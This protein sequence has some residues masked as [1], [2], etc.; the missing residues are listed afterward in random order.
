MRRIV[1]FVIC[2]LSSYMYSQLPLDLALPDDPFWNEDAQEANN[3]KNHFVEPA[4]TVNY[5]D[6]RYVGAHNA[7][8]YHRFFQT[9]RQQDQTTLGMLTYGIRGLMWDTYNFDLSAPAGI[10]GP[11]GAKICLS[12]GV[13]GAIAFG[14]KGHN[15][16]QSL[17]YDFR[18]LIEYMKVNTRAVITLILE[19]YADMAQSVKEMR[20]VLQAAN[21]D[22]VLKPSDWKS[23]NNTNQEWPTLGWTRSNNKRLVIFTQFGGNSSLTWR[24]FNY[25]IENAYSTTDETKLCAQREES[26]KVNALDRKLIVFNNFKGIAVTQATRD[27]KDQVYYDTVKRIITNCQTK[28]FANKRIFNGYWADRIIDSCNDLYGSKQKTIFEYV[29]EL[30]KNATP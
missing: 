11:E 30:N 12:H 27:T 1:L 7:H 3:N 14:Q 22:P 26:A 5:A 9:V 25:C 17:A 2:L 8:V 21:Y 13:P 29:N 18:R 6:Y 16:Y 15:S 24:Q 20:D 19:N 23:A 10:R 28:G 4:D